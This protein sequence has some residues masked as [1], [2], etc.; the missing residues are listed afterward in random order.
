MGGNYIYMKRERENDRR[1]FRNRKKTDR[2]GSRGPQK[3]A[4]SGQTDAWAERLTPNNMH[5]GKGS[6]IL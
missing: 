6:H 5:K 3:S 1:D 4:S 2:G